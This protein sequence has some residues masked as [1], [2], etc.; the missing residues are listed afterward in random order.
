[1]YYSP[2]VSSVD[3][4]I[5]SYMERKKREGDDTV[6]EMDLVL[7]ELLSLDEITEGYEIP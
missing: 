7:N 3:E 6:L 5:P 2:G 4:D 1:M